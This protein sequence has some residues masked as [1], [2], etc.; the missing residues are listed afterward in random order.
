[1]L[2]PGEG[3]DVDSQGTHYIDKGNIGHGAG[4][5]VLLKLGALNS[6]AAQVPTYCASA[7]FSLA[8][9]FPNRSLPAAVLPATAPRWGFPPF[10]LL[11]LCKFKQGAV[12]VWVLDPVSPAA[13]W[14][15]LQS[16]TQPWRL[17]LQALTDF[18][19]S[20]L[21]VQDHT[22]EAQKKQ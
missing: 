19:H 21:P 4:G 9:N 2:P 7:E 20:L 6:T 1:M 12:A 18:G 5:N 16:Q 14:A 8:G 22:H 11:F 3:R 15:P 10:F 17:Q 13:A